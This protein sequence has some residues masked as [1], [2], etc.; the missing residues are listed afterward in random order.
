M[1]K[2]SLL[3]ATGGLSNQ[4][5][6]S[7]ERQWEYCEMET[8]LFLGLIFR[9]ATEVNQIY[10]AV[11]AANGQMHVFE[12]LNLIIIAKLASIRPDLSKED[13]DDFFLA[14]VSDNSMTVEYRGG[15]RVNPAVH[16]FAFKLDVSVDGLLSVNSSSLRDL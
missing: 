11:K 2:R 14:A 5:E 15:K 13:I 8:A 6:G 4:F 1:A 9:P 16:P 7:R 10:V 3:F 12:N